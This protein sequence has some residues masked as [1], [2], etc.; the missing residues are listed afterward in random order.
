MEPRVDRP[1]VP[2]DTMERVAVMAI[3]RGKLGD[4]LYDNVGG[5]LGRTVAHTLSLIERMPPWKAAMAIKPLR[6]V[7]LNKLL[8]QIRAR[9]PA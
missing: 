5:G 9:V 4:L 2:V 6:S 1:F 3:E 8:D 7:F